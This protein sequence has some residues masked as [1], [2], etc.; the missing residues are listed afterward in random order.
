MIGGVE[1]ST[2]GV[3]MKEDTGRGG[4]VRY[5]RRAFLTKLGM[6]AGA[7]LQT[8][9][10]SYV[11]AQPTWQPTLQNPGSGFRTRDFLTYARAD[12]RSRGQ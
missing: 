12:P 2:A 9:P 8:D 3:E 4:P 6:G 10:H 5:G 7:L 1:P 11:V